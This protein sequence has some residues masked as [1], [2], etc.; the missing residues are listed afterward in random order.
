MRATSPVDLV[1]ITRTF[2]NY[3]CQEYTLLQTELYHSKLLIHA[4][5]LVLC[6][7]RMLASEDWQ[8]DYHSIDKEIRCRD[9]DQ[10]QSFQ[11]YLYSAAILQFLQ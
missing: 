1:L 8:N 10:F 7:V 11:K 6:K 5:L 2:K 3:N 9:V 4:P